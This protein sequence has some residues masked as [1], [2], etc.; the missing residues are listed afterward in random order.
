MKSFGTLL[1]AC[2]GGFA[3]LLLAPGAHALPDGPW[4]ECD[5][6]PAECAGPETTDDG[7]TDEYQSP[8]D[9]DDDGIP[10]SE[11]DC[12]FVADKEQ[13]DLDDDLIGDAC[14]N[15]PI[16]EN[17]TQ[18]DMDGDGL[19][20]VCDDDMDGD[21]VLNGNDNCPSIY[22]PS[23]SDIDGDG[24]GD[25]CAPDIDGDG[26]INEEDPCPFGSD[27]DADAGDGGAQQCMGDLDGDGVL[28]FQRIGDSTVPLDNCPTVSNP[29]QADLDGDGI[30]DACDPDRDGD[31]IENPRDNCP[32]APNPDQKDYDRDG[33][34]AACDDRFCYAV[35]G[36]V[37]RCLDPEAP[38]TVYVPNKLDA[39]TG[40]PVRLRLFAN[41]RN[42]ALLYRFEVVSAPSSSGFSISGAKG[43]TGFS[44]PFEYHFPKGAPP[45]LTP[46]E[47]GTYRIRATVTQVWPD[48]ITGKAGVTVEATSYVQVIGYPVASSSNCTCGLVGAGARPLASFLPLLAVLALTGTV[49]RRGG[50]RGR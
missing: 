21:L 6:G 30:G 2:A 42:A 25:A 1:T 16:H 13:S 48:P 41:R 7:S 5:G 50:R 23:Q 44:T 47:D 35:D 9:W 45:T 33:V 15:C 31:G 11:D 32:D 22:N 46:G 10:D 20:D 4:Y 37:D 29:D 26:I 40:E 38:F 24:I 19:G 14:D 27:A 18:S 49:L 3:V 34:G 28:D 17:P 36:D 43:A 8:D 39:N 12:P